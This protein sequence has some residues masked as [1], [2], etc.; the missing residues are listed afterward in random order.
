MTSL[1]PQ[2]LRNFADE[3]RGVARRRRR[4]ARFSF[5]PVTG[6]GSHF[7]VRVTGVCLAG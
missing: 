6:T 1:D 3:I 5:V 4:A 2:M 7:D